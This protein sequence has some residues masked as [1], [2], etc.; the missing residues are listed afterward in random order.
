MK[1]RVVALS[2]A[3]AAMLPGC[4]SRWTL[5]TAPPGIPLQ[6]PFQ[7]NAAKLTFVRSLTGFTK[8]D[9]PG[10]AFKAF[11]FGGDKADSN[12]FVLP[13]AVATGRDGR[14]A[15]ADMGRK[16]VHLFTPE[17]SRYY[18]LIGSKDAKMFSPVAVVF[19][20]DLTLYV[21]DSAGA[22]FV[23]GRDGELRDS[24]RSAGPDAFRRPTGLAYS[25][26][27]RLLYVVDTLAAT[28]YALDTQG[29]LAFTFGGR[30]DGEGRFNFPTH[31]FRS[32]SGDLYVTDTLNFRIVIL[33]ETGKVLG[34]FGRH[35]DG[36]GDMAMPKG[37]AVDR[38]GV[39]YVADSLFDNVQLFDRQGRF[40]LTLGKRGVEAGEFWLPAGLFIDEAG[41]LYVCDTY[42]R[43]VQIFK[44]REKYAKGS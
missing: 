14:I 42:N 32:P 13:V 19:D 6:W 4:A 43:R 29:K 30:G 34:A 8:H 2:L 23:F 10:A 24:W 20:D 36:S 28:I 40:L 5:R 11:V 31:I 26:D 1:R 37:V 15:V 33:D 12:G 41:Q 9:G 22:V 39:V 17:T 38:D 3:L 27:R 21:S 16:C 44:V 25:P 35:G 7:P 18:R